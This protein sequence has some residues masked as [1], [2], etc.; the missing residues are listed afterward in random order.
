MHLYGSGGD[1]IFKE[2]SDYENGSTLVVQEFRQVNWSGSIG[3]G[4]VVGLEEWCR[5]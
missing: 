2:R 3:I 1:Q 5:P 4:I